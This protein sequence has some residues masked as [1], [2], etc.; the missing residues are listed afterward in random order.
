MK[1]SVLFYLLA[2]FTCIVSGQTEKLLVPSDLK[3]QTIVT[4]P[5]TLRKGFFRSGLLVNYRV[6]DRFFNGEGE[7]EYYRTSSWGSTAAYGLT[8]QYGIT[9]RFEAL[10]VTEYRNTLTETQSTGIITGINKSLIISEKHKGIG[11]GDSHVNMKYQ[12]IPEAEGK[13][14]LT[15]GLKVT[16]PTGEKNPRNISNENRYDLPVG[17][18]TFAMGLSLSGRKINYPYSYSGFL[19]YTNN[20]NG[21]RILT[22]TDEAERKFRFGN[23]F[24]TG[25]SI[26]LHLN[27]WIVF[28]NDAN[29]Y[30][31]GEGMIENAPAA[32][33]PAS[34]A[35]SYEPGLIFQVFRFRLGESV[36]M[37]VAG[38]NVPAD[39][40][41]V[42]LAQ[43]IF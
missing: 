3:Q 34:W 6:A 4:E 8:L 43:Y 39:P 38:K 21:Y 2:S 32:T 33:M 40:L 41:F 30:N 5:V 20:F 19:S 11:I 9:D 22:V 16:V 27:E 24:E 15:G 13:L 42:I 10:L 25:I 1:K 35:L 31:E 29:F 7:K 28:T 18:G 14:S 12:V 23:L 36:R 26:N 17:N 37:P